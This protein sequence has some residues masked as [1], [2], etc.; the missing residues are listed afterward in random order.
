MFGKLLTNRL[1]FNSMLKR[2][3]ITKIWSADLRDQFESKIVLIEFDCQLFCHL[4][5]VVKFPKAYNDSDIEWGCRVNCN[6]F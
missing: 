6:R 2:K 1:Q 5:F 4:N 3:R